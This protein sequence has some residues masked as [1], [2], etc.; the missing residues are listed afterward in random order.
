MGMTY[1]RGHRPVGQVLPERQLTRRW[2]ALGETALDATV[3]GNACERLGKSRLLRGER[4]PQQFF[5]RTFPRRLLRDKPAFSSKL[6][7]FPG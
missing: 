6:L 5:W 3:G 4:Q 7:S 1:K 2:I